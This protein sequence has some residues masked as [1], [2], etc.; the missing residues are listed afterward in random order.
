[1]ENKSENTFVVSIVIVNHNGKDQTEECLRSFFVHTP[2]DPFEVL[3]VDND[4]KDGSVELL[5]L[6]FPQ[7]R[8]LAQK[9]NY[10]FGKANNI[11]VGESSGKFFFFV[12]NDTIFKEDIV[13]PLS[14]FLKENPSCG[15]VGPLLLNSDGT[16]QH[17]YGKFPSLMNELRTKR[18]TAR[19][20]NIPKDRSPKLVDWI[21]FA[22]V[23]MRRSAFEKVRGFDERYF[24]YLE[25]VDLC[26]RLQNA[27]YQS[28]YCSKYSIIHVGRGSRTAENTC[29][30]KIEYRRSQIIFYQ[31]NRSRYE[32]LA[33]RIYLVFR[34]LFL[35]ISRRVDKRRQAYSVIKMALSFNVHRS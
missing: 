6:K 27:G 18:D 15:A 8:V 17:S 22:V 4:S 26:F 25:D 12:N 35:T 20:K 1:M 34:F 2:D 24:M 5:K 28:F 10:G 31:L 30:V 23:M 11:G 16:Y 3:V 9:K 32:T 33:L 14:Q 7:I 21:S 19:F 13:T 29:K